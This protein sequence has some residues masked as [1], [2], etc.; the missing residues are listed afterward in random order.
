MHRKNRPFYKISIA[1]CHNSWKESLKPVL[2][3][4]VCKYNLKISFKYTV[5]LVLVCLDMNLK[6]KKGIFCYLARPFPFTGNE[7]LLTLNIYPAPGMGTQTGGMWVSTDN[8]AELRPDHYPLCSQG[9][10]PGTSPGS[11]LLWNSVLYL[12][13]PE[14]V[15]RCPEPPAIAEPPRSQPHRRYISAAMR[16]HKKKKSFL[17][18]V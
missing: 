11:A 15:R 17:R 5:R 8:V 2:K 12:H 3:N 14:A 6:I 18:L 4:N 16:R 13:P 1:R 10:G 9:L 7:F